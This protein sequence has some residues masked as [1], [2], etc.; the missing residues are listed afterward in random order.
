MGLSRRAPLLFCSRHFIT[1]TAHA[2][3]ERAPVTDGR[4]ARRGSAPRQEIAQIDDGGV[5]ARNIV[6]HRDGIICE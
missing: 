3:R 4:H 2:Q 5:G 1:G 6:G